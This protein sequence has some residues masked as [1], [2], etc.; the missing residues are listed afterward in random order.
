MGLSTTSAGAE[1]EGL[2]YIV[3]WTQDEAVWEWVRTVAAALLGAV[4]G[5]LFTLRGQT[6]AAKQQLDRDEKARQAA[7]EDARREDTKADARALFESFI[8]LE[9]AISDA[10][11]TF[12]QMIG[13]Q[14]W[15]PTWKTIWTKE[16]RRVIRAQAGLIPDRTTR[17][18]L[19]QV[20]Y[21]LNRARDQSAEGNWPGAPDRN[22]YHLVQA[23]ASEG[24]EIVEAYLRRDPF[25]TRRIGFIDRLAQTDAEFDTWQREESERYDDTMRDIARQESAE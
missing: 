17:E 7:L 25:V 10:D 1:L 14:A 5:G 4:I 15:Y 11:R 20:V 8:D 12:A 2:W 16:R 23:L 18:S 13:E 22:L 6:R 9:R 24:T 19:T 21:F 3:W